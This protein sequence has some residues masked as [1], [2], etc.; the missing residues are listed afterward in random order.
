MP[1][2]YSRNSLAL[3]RTF[4]VV[5]DE[6]AGLSSEQAV[7]VARALHREETW[8][9]LL[10]R[11]YIVVLGEAG[12]GKS[13][14][15]DR[16]AAQLS[17]EGQ[18]A[19]FVEI[20]S[21]A[22]NGLI[23]S[24]D[25]EDAERIKAWRGTDAR[26]VFFL[27]SLDEAKL[28]RH[29]LRDGLRQLRNA[30]H[31]EWT[32]AALVVSCRVS[33]WMAGA[34]RYEIAAVIPDG[35]PATVYV[36][37]IAPLETPQVAKLAAH[38]G[39]T[40]V[41]SFIT[42]I[43][44]NY[45]QAFIERPLDVK[46]LGGYWN[47]HRRIGSLRELIDD[48]I[49]EKLRE[50]PGRVSTL[51][52]AKAVEGLQALAG[53]ATLTRRYSFL[54]PDESLELVRGDSAVDPHEVL[55]DWS[56][57]EIQQLLRRPIFD[58]SSYGRVRIHHRSVQEFLAA[59]WFHSL[60]TAGMMRTTLESLFLRRTGGEQ[61]VPQHL[62]PVLAWLCLWDVD[63]RHKMLTEIPAL[64]I[65]HG[66][67]S[68]FSDDERRTIL[69]AYASRY[70]DRERQFQTFDLPSLDRFSSPILAEPIAALLSLPDTPEDLA[71]MLLQLAEH[72]R[73]MEC[74]PVALSLAMGART[75]NYVRSY[76]IRAAAALGGKGDLLALVDQLEVWDQ[77]V[78]G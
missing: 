17:S 52:A 75:P 20:T 3:D 1:S 26:A 10:Q 62:G 50:R 8:A 35:S 28:R 31:A 43:N 22:T 51:P 57:D 69:R 76:A 32:R 39:V 40:D 7:P 77:D 11:P 58:E 19:F 5:S 38:V 68:G 29:T 4:I 53:I 13:T 45:A 27:D 74:A 34:D 6:S 15:F 36:V 42:A 59:R 9:Q 72:G 12:T 66:D 18:W 21:L 73:I 54:V 24:I 56:D 78:A 46:W 63:L 37:Q 70:K 67:P 55:H 61:A 33:D 49:R 48:D 30:I 60:L 64:L 65:G 14:E 41:A 2:R 25:P 23:N 16:Q 47:S 71:G 44:D